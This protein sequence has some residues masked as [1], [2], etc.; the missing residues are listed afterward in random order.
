[1]AVIERFGECCH[2]ALSNS[3]ITTDEVEK[4][5]LC[6]G[7]HRKGESKNQNQNCNRVSLT[8][9]FLLIADSAKEAETTEPQAQTSRKREK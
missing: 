1:M 7:V 5:G 8:T 4:V 3:S 9:V 2:G 6:R